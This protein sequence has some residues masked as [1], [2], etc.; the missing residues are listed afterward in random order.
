MNATP[1]PA[2]PL[3]PEIP[4][5]VCPSGAPYAG[6]PGEEDFQS[7]SVPRALPSAATT[8]PPLAAP[9]RPPRAGEEHAEGANLGQHFALEI[10]AGSAGLTAALTAVNFDATGIDWSE[11][12][13]KPKGKVVQVNLSTDNGV[14]VFWR[15]LRHPRLAYC[16][17]A[18]PCGTASRAREKRMSKERHGPPPLRSVEFPLGLPNLASQHPQAVRR[19]EV[20]NALY[21]LT[22]E[23]AKYLTKRGV[24]W[25]IENPINSLFWFIP[26]IRELLD[27]SPEVGDILMHHCMHGGKRDKQSRFRC[28]PSAFF[29]PLR[30]ACD[31]N[32]EH[33]PWGFLLNAGVFATALEAEYP[34]ALCTNIATCALAAVTAKFGSCLPA[35]AGLQPQPTAR[36]TEVVARTGQHS[37]AGALRPDQV[38]AGK[39]PRGNRAPPVVPLVKGHIFAVVPAELVETLV[40]DSAATTDIVGAFGRIPK[41]AKG[42]KSIVFE[43]SSGTSTSAYRRPVRSDTTAAAFMQGGLPPDHVY[44][45]R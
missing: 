36:A 6:L 16:H 17:F 41:D 10:F 29:E 14:A 27:L 5:D 13:H 18:P 23:A 22:A 42:V 31:G 11:N 3:V 19:V 30:L 28:Y 33:E 44:V 32:H 25:T 37:T 40:S 45:G 43:G 1:Q 7:A 35:A 24:P 21:K 38:A 9:P 26:W 20:A 34:E 39:Q 4:A 12:R 15:M 8:P 2:N